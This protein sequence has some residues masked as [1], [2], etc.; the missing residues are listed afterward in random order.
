MYIKNIQVM[1]NLNWE[2]LAFEFQTTSISLAEMGKRENVDRRTLSKHFK[3]LGVKIVNKQNRAKF[4][5]YIF[6]S[7]DTEEKA[8]WLGFIFADGYINSSPIESNKKSIYG[9]E[10]SLQLLDLNH[11]IKFKDF[12]SYEKNLI[13]DAYRCRFAIANKHLWETLNSY[14]CAPRKSLTLE[15][16]S[17]DIFIESNEYSKKELI[18]HF[19]RGYFDGD[20]CI[21]RYVNKHIVS[22][23]IEVLGT[24]NF[25]N[26][27]LHYS[28]IEAAIRHDKRHSK[29]IITLDYHVNEGTKFINYLY[30]ESNIYLDR[31]Y[32]LFNFFKQG[33]RSVEEFTELLQTN[34]GENLET[35][36]TEISTETKE[37][38]PSYSVE[39]EPS[40]EE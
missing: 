34:I 21:S 17:E 32:K 24:K 3:E 39:I 10:L 15:F 19:I 40:I 2:Q 26:G 35:E 23:H 5:E 8:Y 14:G 37:S 31:K 11:L 9:F 7:I 16:P 30:S 1:K 12:V 20:G 6:D 4:N 27:I 18:R 22:V 36:N 33:S 13:T 29:N 38:V 28:K 25:I